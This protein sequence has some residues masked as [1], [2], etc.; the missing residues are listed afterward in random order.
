MSEDRLFTVVVANDVEGLRAWRASFSG[1]LYKEWKKPI[2]CQPDASASHFIRTKPG[3]FSASRR[4]LDGAMIGYDFDP[5]GHTLLGLAVSLELYSVLHEMLLMIA[6]SGMEKS[7]MKKLINR[8]D[9]KANSAAYLASKLVSW[10]DKDCDDNKYLHLLV[11]ECGA[12]FKLQEEAHYLYTND[13]MALTLGFFVFIGYVIVIKWVSI[14]QTFG[15]ASG[16]EIDLTCN[17]LYGIKIKPIFITFL[18][19]CTM[20]ILQYFTSNPRYTWVFI[21]IIKALPWPLWRTDASKKPT[22]TSQDDVDNMESGTKHHDQIPEPMPEAD[23]DKHLQMKNAH[24]E[25]EVANPVV[26]VA[27]ESVDE[28][29]SPSPSSSTPPRTMKKA[30]IFEGIKALAVSVSATV[31]KMSHPQATHWV[32]RRLATR[33]LL[34]NSTN[35]EE[36]L[37]ARRA[38]FE[39]YVI[40]ASSYDE[41][42]RRIG[43][44]MRNNPKFQF[45]F[46]QCAK[47]IFSTLFSIGTAQPGRTA[48]ES[49]VNYFGRVVNADLPTVIFSL[50]APIHLEVDV[51]RQLEE[52]EGCRGFLVII[53]QILVYIFNR[54]RDLFSFEN[55]GWYFLLLLWPFILIVPPC[56]THFLVAV[57]LYCWIFF[58]CLAAALVAWR[59]KFIFFRILR[60]FSCCLDVWYLLYVSLEILLRFAFVVGCQSL[61]NVVSIIYLDGGLPPSP[62]NYLYGLTWTFHLMTSPQCFGQG[63][64]EEQVSNLLVYL[65]IC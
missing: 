6:S 48:M 2:T 36:E 22:T 10:K 40:D 50:L 49:Y 42:R 20:R 17:S 62:H 51:V 26:T 34:P 58:I 8:L 12:D 24:E 35:D 55:F 3:K 14:V 64:T 43:P 4:S 32:D 53:W 57:G 11:I 5:E 47:F 37:A 33:D 25:S 19:A 60:C 30:G 21:A 9:A 59:F 45:I 13:L 18:D 29:S 61:F 31:S 23:D 7:K 41:V 54:L 65:S 52:Q 28:P 15:Q 44:E 39:N 38:V 46:F 27:A 63:G 16:I 1:S 56:L